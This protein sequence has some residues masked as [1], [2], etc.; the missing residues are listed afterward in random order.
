M[1]P[2][3]KL[4]I[5]FTLSLALIISCGKGEKMEQKKVTY[6]SIQQIPEATW[7]KLSEKKIFF[8]HQSVGFN[9]IDG[10]KDVMK[11]Y[12]AIKL[13][14][15]ETN[16]PGE[17]DKPVF[18]H[19]RA[20]KNIDPESKCDA[21]AEYLRNGIGK[22]A[23][24]AFLKFCYV[25]VRANSDVQKVFDY[26]K[27]TIESLEKEYPDVT[28]VH[29]TVPLTVTKTSIKTWIKKIIGKK[30]IWEYDDNI[31]RNEY[32]DLLR[33]YYSGKEPVFDIAEI[34]STYPDGKRCTF[35]KDGKTYYSLVPE[36]T[37]DGGHLN[38][39]GRKIVA[40]KLLVLLA[41]LAS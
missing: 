12:P 2:A 9:I 16:D 27:K 34:E 30:D 39:K 40:E 4:T 13:N 41:N 1:K 32:N 8:G 18:E 26:Y 28:F 38:E 37:N 36:Y 3:I 5:L 11:E 7:K 15:V 6:T 33:K 23:D 21:F 25:D 14:I 35:S 29:F 24:I 10:I 17:F 20:G 31:K 22:K 19:S